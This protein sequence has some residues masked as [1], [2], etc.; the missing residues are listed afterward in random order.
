MANRGDV[1]SARLG[2][3]VAM[4]LVAALWAPV[5]AAP[6][7]PCE[8]VPMPCIFEALPFTFR[9]VDAETRQPLGDVHALAEWQTHGGWSGGLNGPLMVLDVV[10]GVDGVLGFPGWGPLDGPL[11]GLG[12]GRD[13][14]ITLFKTG[15]KPIIIG[16]G[17]RSTEK[18]RVR[19][20]AQDGWTYSLE[21][22][23]G[24]PE[25]WIK[26]LARVDR[27]VAFPR[28]DDQSL[29]FRAPY[30]NRLR[31]VWEERANVPQA[32]RGE[33]DFFWSVGKWIKFLQEGHR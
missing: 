17:G 5:W 2:M 10:S 1:G 15:Y 16:N 27:G 3:V 6:E 23:V 22:F 14:I 12:V 28:S 30:L 25:E 7:Q 32:L 13:P 26:E 21:R 31:R 11:D 24:T 18:Q 33:R 19:R 9:V 4:L 20:F 29:R 8:V